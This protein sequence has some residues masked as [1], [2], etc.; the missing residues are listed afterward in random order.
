MYD[1]LWTAAK[2]MYKT[3]PAIADGGEVVIYAPRLAEVSHTHGELIDEV[4]YHAYS[5][6]FPNQDSL[7]L[8]ATG[9][10]TAA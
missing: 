5:P 8:D 2:A 1:D 9:F 4:G 10:T 6:R 7:G 3:E